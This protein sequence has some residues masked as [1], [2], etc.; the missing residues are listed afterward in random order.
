MIEQVKNSL[1]STFIVTQE[2][3]NG[4]R[5][6]KQQD[7]QTPSQFVNEQV[8]ETIP[9]TTQQRISPIH[10]TLTTP[11]K[12]STPFPQTILQ[13]TVKL[14]VFPK[15]LPYGLLSKYTNN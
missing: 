3:L 5:N 4:T 11:H 2:N 7:I 13:S 12:K 14:S 8:V 10:P 15:T 1:N 6:V 9:T